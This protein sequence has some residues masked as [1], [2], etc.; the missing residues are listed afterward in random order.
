MNSKLTRSLLSLSAVAVLVLCFAS[1]AFAKEEEKEK[2]EGAGHEES[3]GAGG[4]KTK[5]PEWIALQNQINQLEGKMQQ[6]KDAIE[7]LVEEK[8]HLPQSSPQVSEIVEQMKAEYKEYLK[9]VE[10]FDKKVTLLKYRFP[11]R[12]LKGTRTYEPVEAK[13][14]DEM[15]RELGTDGR[16]SRNMKKIRN[17]YRDPSVPEVKEV[18]EK[19]RVVKPKNEDKSIDE[20]GVII[21]QK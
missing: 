7:K 19:V 5:D 12:G 14:L 16:L 21:L 1:P 13:P 6:K 11:E 8:Q 2:S 17:Q 9:T 10:E 3:K 18:D 15:E 4:V 20:A